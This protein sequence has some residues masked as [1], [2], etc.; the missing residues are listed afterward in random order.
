MGEVIDINIL[1]VDCTNNSLLNVIYS[2]VSSYGALL[3]LFVGEAFDINILFTDLANNT[4]LN[5]I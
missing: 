5:I 3:E 2:S 1:M 4:A